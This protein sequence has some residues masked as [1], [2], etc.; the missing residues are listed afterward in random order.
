LNVN[1]S[2]RKILE[3]I[4][5][6]PTVNVLIAPKVQIAIVKALEPFP[7]AQQAVADALGALELEEGESKNGT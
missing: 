6:E 4:P 2:L 1:L 7:D 5:S 3:V